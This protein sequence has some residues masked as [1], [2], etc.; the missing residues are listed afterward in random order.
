LSI[1]NGEEFSVNSCVKVRELCKLIGGFGCRIIQNQEG[2]CT[3]D[4]MFYIPRVMKIK[5]V[6]ELLEEAMGY[7]YYY[8]NVM[9]HSAFRYQIPFAH[10]KSQPPEID[11]RI[12]F[13]IPIMLD[14]VSVK[15]G[16]WRVYYVLAYHL[17]VLQ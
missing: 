12:Q 5:S 13:L 1:D 11:D 2:Y 9:E 10:L 4:H 16:P 17:M 3:N 8:D 7:I 14:K 15:L 6:S